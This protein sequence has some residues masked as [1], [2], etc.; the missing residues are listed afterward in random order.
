MVFGMLPMA[1][2]IARDQFDSAGARVEGGLN[3]L[4]TPPARLLAVSHG[5][6]AGQAPDLASPQAFNASFKPLLQEFSQL[7]SVVAGTSTGQGWLL[8]QQ[9]GGAWRNRMTCL[10]YTSRCV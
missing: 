2:Q 6:L 3:A 5:W 7:T 4:F 9:P 10:L 1:D 8:L